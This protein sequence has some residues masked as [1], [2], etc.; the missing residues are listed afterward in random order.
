MWR[1]WGKGKTTII[2]LVNAAK[3]AKGLA[4]INSL[5]DKTKQLRYIQVLPESG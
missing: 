4:W 3:V 2:E 5:S 1:A